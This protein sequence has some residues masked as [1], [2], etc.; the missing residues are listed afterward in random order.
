MAVRIFV[1]AGHQA[2][3]VQR[4]FFAAAYAHAEEAKA[5]RFP[6]FGPPLRVLEVRV[7]AVD[8]DVVGFQC[9]LQVAQHGVHGLAGRHHHP[10]AARRFQRVHELS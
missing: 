2:R 6:I 1:P 3:A 9:G 10:D 5:D 8:D 7:A 4:A